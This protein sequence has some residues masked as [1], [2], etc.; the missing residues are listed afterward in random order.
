MKSG[1]LRLKNLFHGQVIGEKG[2]IVRVATFVK[3][4]S[5]LRFESCHTD[6]CE[7]R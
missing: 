7:I 1:T 3:G 4:S 5:S 6:Y 2:K